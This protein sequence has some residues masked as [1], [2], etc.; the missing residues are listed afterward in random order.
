MQSQVT[1]LVDELSAAIDQSLAHAS[2]SSEDPGLLVRLALVR[3]TFVRLDNAMMQEEAVA[4]EAARAALH[5]MSPPELP[6]LQPLPATNGKAVSRK[7][8]KLKGPR[9]YVCPTCHA[10]VGTSCFKMSNKGQG[11]TVT[12]ERHPEG[13]GPYHTSRQALS[14]AS[15]NAAKAKYD[16]EHS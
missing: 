15:N 2:T 4:A 1:T 12:T 14:K 3:G 8:L 6:R 10:E 7:G 5:A 11:A 13:T 9:D 16:K